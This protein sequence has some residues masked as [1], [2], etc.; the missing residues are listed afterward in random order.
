M[1]N[2]QHSHSLELRYTLFTRRN[3]VDNNMEPGLGK[4]MRIGP[5]PIMYVIA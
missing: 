2:Y 3:G 5:P 4:L 1:F